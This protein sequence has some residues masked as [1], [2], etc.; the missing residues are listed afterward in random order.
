MEG[1]LGWIYAP[2]L[3]DSKPP[4]PPV[5]PTPTNPSTSGVAETDKNQE[6]LPESFQPPMAGGGFSLSLE[7]SS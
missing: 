1:S 2:Q 3:Q 6:K 5:L 4:F 7:G